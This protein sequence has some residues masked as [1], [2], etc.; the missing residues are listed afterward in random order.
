M[1]YD[2]LNNLIFFYLHVFNE[3]QAALIEHVEALNVKTR[4]FEEY[5]LKPQVVGMVVDGDPINL[6]FKS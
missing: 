3:L 1:T 4:P 5:V 2:D 6:N